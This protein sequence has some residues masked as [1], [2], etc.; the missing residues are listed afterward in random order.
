MQGS[1][2][3]QSITLYVPKIQKLPLVPHVFD[4][5]SELKFLNFSQPYPDEQILSLP[6]GLE[7]L[8]N[9]LRFLHWV[10]Y[11]LKSLPSTFCPESL[12]ELILPHSRV[13][14]LWDGVLVRIDTSSMS[15]N[16][17]YEY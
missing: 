2:A 5:M 13:E 6:Q 1:K 3:I 16:H 15:Q 14:K 8:P 7:T 11:P 9:G 17:G 4:E 12:V 10:S